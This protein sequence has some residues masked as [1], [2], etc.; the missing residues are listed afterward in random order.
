MQMPRPPGGVP[1]GLLGFNNGSVG[2]D[3]LETADGNIA[4]F[5]EFFHHAIRK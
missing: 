5:Q 1:L 3:V 4:V 2:V